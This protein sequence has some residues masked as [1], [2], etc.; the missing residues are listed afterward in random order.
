MSE[1]LF[2]ERDHVRIV[3]NFTLW[4]SANLVISTVAL[5]SLAINIFKL[6]VWDGLVAISIFNALGVFPVAFFFHPRTQVGT[7]ANDKIVVLQRISC[8]PK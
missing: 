5:G 1:F 7:P 8:T 6:G 3:D 2:S 4:L